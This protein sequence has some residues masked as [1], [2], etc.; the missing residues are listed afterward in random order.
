MDVVGVVPSRRQRQHLVR[1]LVQLPRRRLH[2]RYARV[3]RL[4]LFGCVSWSQALL[5]CVRR[6]SPRAA[7]M[8]MMLRRAPT[9]RSS[10]RRGRGLARP[11]P[12]LTQRA[13]RHRRRSP[14]HFF[15]AGASRFEVGGGTRV[16]QS[17]SWKKT[18]RFR[19]HSS[20]LTLAADRRR[21]SRLQRYSRSYKGGA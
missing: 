17:S 10:Q 13:R 20:V 1:H 11:P 8:T 16:K 3:R 12:P 19:D 2:V 5:L 21:P 18:E 15:F 9:R 7:T 14:S 4:L 6:G